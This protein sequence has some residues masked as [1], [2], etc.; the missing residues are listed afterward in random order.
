MKGVNSGIDNVK[1]LFWPQKLNKKIENIS[2][3]WGTGH[4]EITYIV[5]RNIIPGKT[6]VDKYF[7][8]IFSELMILF[9]VKNILGAVVINV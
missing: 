3:P 7:T 4:L 6:P 2:A 1:L 5:T 8:V 9:A